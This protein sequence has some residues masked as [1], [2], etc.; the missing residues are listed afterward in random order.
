MWVGAKILSKR[1]YN[2]DISNMVLAYYGSILTCLFC[3]VVLALYE[4]IFW[5]QRY[6]RSRRECIMDVPTYNTKD[7]INLFLESAYKEVLSSK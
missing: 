2:Y 1:F 7:L 4:N 3:F 6:M 5:K